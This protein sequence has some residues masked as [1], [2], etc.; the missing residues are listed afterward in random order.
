MA[1]ASWGL[2]RWKK[3]DVK[4]KRFPCSL[5]FIPPQSW[6]QPLRC[7]CHGGCSTTLLGEAGH[8]HPGHTASHC[9]W[10]RNITMTTAIPHHWYSSPSRL[11]PSPAALPSWGPSPPPVLNTISMW[12][13]CSESVRCTE[14]HGSVSTYPCDGHSAATADLGVQ[15]LRMGTSCTPLEEPMPQHQPQDWFSLLLTISMGEDRADFLPAPAAVPGVILSPANA[16]AL[17]R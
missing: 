2:S 16:T 6:P 4:H 9:A 10:T 5:I 8:S 17:F 14:D 13:R 12:M 1:L 11:A 3:R 15:S 7:C